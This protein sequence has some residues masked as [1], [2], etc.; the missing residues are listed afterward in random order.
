M[1]FAGIMQY[2][3]SDRLSMKWIRIKGSTNPDCLT[4]PFDLSATATAGFKE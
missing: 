2:G 4:A 3:S 1:Q